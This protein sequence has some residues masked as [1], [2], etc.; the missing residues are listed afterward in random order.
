MFAYV[1]RQAIYTVEKDV[2]AYELLFRDGKRNCFPD[3]SPDTATST[4]LT[5]SHLSIGLENITFQKTAFINFHEDTLLYRFPST[6]DPLSTVIE[7]VESVKVTEA[8]IQA[9][10]HVRDLGYSLA[11]DDYNFDPKWEPLIPLVKYIKIESSVVSNANDFVLGKIEKLLTA[12]KVLIAEKVETIDEFVL[13][14]KMGFTLF[15]GYFLSKPE[16]VEHKK[17]EV[18]LSSVIE[19]VGISAKAEFDFDEVNEIFEKDLGLSYKL[20]RFINNP[21]LN[22]RQKINSLGHALKFLG[23]IELKKFIALLAIANLKGDKPMDLITTSLTRAHFCKRLSELLAFKEN[24]PEGFILGLFS[25]VDALIDIP[26]PKVTKSL[27][28]SEQ[29]NT[30]LCQKFQSDES[31]LSDL[32][33]LCI[34]FERAHWKAIEY[35]CS[36]LSIEE[37]QGFE[38]YYDAM[39][40][41]EDMRKSLPS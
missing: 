25:L 11:L 28:F 17:I 18:A 20:M 30:A 38:A 5:D 29:V 39:K 26:M 10:E 1:A 37:A 13:L 7:I 14:E 19:L 15:Q 36:K 35:L 6:L 16:I 21:T 8:L 27:P 34:A 3:I 40:W 12:E 22:K 33:A 24:P 32:L 4:M 31:P 2:F 41:A 23:S 9:L